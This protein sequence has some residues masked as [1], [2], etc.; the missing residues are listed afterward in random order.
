MS[1]Q[2]YLDTVFQKTG[3][4]PADFRL[5]AEEKG[6][7]GDDIATGRIIAWLGEDFSLGRGH[8]MA[9]V[10]TLR[11]TAGS[12]APQNE[13]LDKLFAGGRTKWRPLYETLLAGI[14]ETDPVELGLTNTYISLLKP[15][16]G[17]SPGVTTAPGKKFAIVS[18]SAERLDLGFK[19]KGDLPLDAAVPLEPSGSWN[20]MV[21]HR[22]RVTDPAAATV[23][24]LELLREAYSRN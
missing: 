5:L 20:A 9:I 11:P 3:K 1:F 22:L 7:L 24:L 12:V 8:A 4:T 16:N 6:L 19:L 17:K 14:R 18:P 15:A 21:T 23:P 10:Q 13:Q 2:A